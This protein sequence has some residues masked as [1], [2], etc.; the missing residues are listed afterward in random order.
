LVNSLLGWQVAIHGDEGVELA[1]GSPQ[2]CA[3]HDEAETLLAA[4]S[5]L[6]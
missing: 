1:C 6:T 2:Q 3:V 5:K 4:M